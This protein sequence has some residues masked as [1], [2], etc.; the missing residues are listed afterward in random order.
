MTTV[1]QRAEQIRREAGAWHA[2]LHSGEINMNVRDQFENWLHADRDHKSVYRDYEQVYRDLE[3]SMPMAGVNVDEILGRNKQNVVDQFKEW[4]KRPVH[5]VGA[6]G[7]V[8]AIMLIFTM[9][10]P[11]MVD[12][13]LRIVNLPEVSYSTE[14]AEISEITLEDGTIVTLGAKSQIEAQFTTTNRRVNLLSGEA[15]FNVTKDPN[16]PF[17]VAV[18]DTLVRVVGTQFEVKNLKGH[19]QVTV[20]EGI[21]EVMK[22]EIIPDIIDLAS[23]SV[24]KKQVLT[25]GQRITGKY[26]FPLPE[27]ENAEHLEAGSWRKGRLAYEDA[28]LSEIIGDLNRYHARQVKLV[29]SDLNDLRMT[30][31]FATTDIEQV[32]KTLEALHPVKVEYLSASEILI[33][34]KF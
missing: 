5:A 6:L 31:S 10:Q 15:F 13:N 9:Q 7:S 24:K 33:H 2:R 3:I 30:I 17:Y 22:P 1:D 14:I 19:V 32:L 27:V 18:D 28:P 21:V 4:I 11:T 29:D 23:L 20:L 12:P 34:H 25:A 26:K 8:L 16:R